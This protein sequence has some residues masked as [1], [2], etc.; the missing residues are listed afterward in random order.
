MRLDSLDRRTR[1]QSLPP[2][3]R[4][5]SYPRPA[6]SKSSRP[7]CSFAM[8]HSTITRMT[9]LAPARRKQTS[10]GDDQLR[11]NRHFGCF[12]FGTLWPILIE[13]HLVK[14]NMSADGFLNLTH[15]DGYSSEKSSLRAY[16]DFLKKTVRIRQH[17]DSVSHLGGSPG[18]PPKNARRGAI[19][20]G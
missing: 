7:A 5:A 10:G 1:M 6:I 19:H 4:L 15:S 13:N 8:Q 17:Q 11:A 18:E 12:V 9:E 16:R 2:Q 14:R 3:C 20:G